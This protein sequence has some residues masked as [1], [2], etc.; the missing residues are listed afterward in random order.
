MTVDAAAKQE[1]AEKGFE[2]FSVRSVA[3]RSGVSRPSLMLRWPDKDSLIIETLASISEWPSTDPAGVLRDELAKLVQ[4]MVDLLDPTTIAIQLRLI[5]D[6]SR[7]P[8]L[9]AAFQHKVMSSAGH[10]LADLLER[11]V[12]RGE[13]A[14]GIDC[15]WAADALVGVVFL[16]TIASP[17]LRPLSATAQRRLI[18]SMMST[19][20]AGGAKQVP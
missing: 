14:V 1:L 10:Q 12:A 6:A 16:R 15:R 4:A 19:V 5:A 17:E 9:F 3:R 8:K 20:R 13:L 7:H 11:A 18:D 2:A